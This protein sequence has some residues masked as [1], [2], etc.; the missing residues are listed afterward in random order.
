MPAGCDTRLGADRRGP[1]PDS[2]F[3]ARRADAGVTTP[4]AAAAPADLLL[5][6]GV[7]GNISSADVQQTVAA[8][9]ILCAPGATVMWTRHRREPDLTRDIR[10]W[11]AKAGFEE[12]AFISPGAGR[13]S[14]GAHRLVA[15]PQPYV[16]DLHRSPSSHGRL[17][18][19]SD[20]RS[21]SG[22]HSCVHHGPRLPSPPC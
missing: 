18:D 20:R 5:A 1:L 3:K 10:F 17:C 9:P 19:V 16:P 21:A 22:G 14:V 2:R 15:P 12:V 6:C 7:F 8:L 4:Y 13:F 11:F